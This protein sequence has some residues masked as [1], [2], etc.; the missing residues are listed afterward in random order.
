[1]EGSSERHIVQPPPGHRGKPRACCLGQSP[2]IFL[3]KLTALSQS[4]ILTKNKQTKKK[5]T[6]PH[7]Q[8]KNLP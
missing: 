2:D 5:P 4:T 1:M 3:F 8:Q 6:S 7:I